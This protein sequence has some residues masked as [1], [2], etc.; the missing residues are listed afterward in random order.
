MRDIHGERVQRCRDGYARNRNNDGDG[1][2]LALARA[3]NS[4]PS[5]SAVYDSTDDD[6]VITHLLAVSQ[7]LGRAGPIYLNESD[8]I[9]SS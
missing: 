1:R 9:L 8:N 4:L 7:E 6:Q 2:P 5:A 3:L